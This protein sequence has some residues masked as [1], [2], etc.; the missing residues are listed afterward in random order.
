MTDLEY[1]LDEA[2][3]AITNTY[4]LSVQEQIGQDDGGVASMFESGGEFKDEIARPVVTQLIGNDHSDESFAKVEKIFDYKFIT[5]QIEKR[6][7]R[8]SGVNMD[9]NEDIEAISKATIETLNKAIQKSFLI[10]LAL[11]QNRSFHSAK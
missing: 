11:I 9:N 1:K 4:Y 6:W 8:P 10:T 5:S 7:D 3:E 2:A